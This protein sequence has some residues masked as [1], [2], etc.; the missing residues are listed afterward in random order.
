MCVSGMFITCMQVCAH[1]HMQKSKRGYW[2]IWLYLSP[3]YAL[4]IGSPTEP[5]GRLV[6]N[7]PQEVSWA[8]PAQHWASASITGATSH[9]QIFT[10]LWGL[11][12]G[13]KCLCNTCSYLLSQDPIPEEINFY[14]EVEL[15][16]FEV[17]VHYLPS[18]ISL[19]RCI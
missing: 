2:V 13:S 10:W 19:S 11:E 1:V 12:L 15:R 6:A 4:E 8:Q 16:P 17:C 9:T 5:G 14:Q 3:T 7:K 18:T